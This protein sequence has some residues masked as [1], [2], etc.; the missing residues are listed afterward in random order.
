[1]PLHDKE[2]PIELRLAIITLKYFVDLSF[3]EIEKATGIKQNT[4]SSIYNT[5]RQRAQDPINF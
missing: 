4:A 5:A 1:M 2:V 3:I